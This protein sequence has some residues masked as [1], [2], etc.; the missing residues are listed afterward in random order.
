MCFAFKIFLSRNG[1]GYVYFTYYAHTQIYVCICAEAG[2]WKVKTMSAAGQPQREPILTLRGTWNPE[3]QTLAGQPQRELS[4]KLFTQI[5]V[6]LRFCLASALLC[7]ASLRF[8][9][10]WYQNKT[11]D[12]YD[13]TFNSLIFMWSQSRV[14]QCF[15][16]LD[17]HVILLG[18]LC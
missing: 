18:Y 3:K 1:Y 8:C 5:C 2:G 7:F 4:E 16:F 14:W 12:T 13:L 6:S 9:F 11:T 15:T 10:A 17:V